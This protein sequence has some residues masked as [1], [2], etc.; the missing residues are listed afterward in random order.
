MRHK[1]VSNV[2]DFN[3]VTTKNVLVVVF[4]G[5]QRFD[6]LTKTFRNVYTYWLLWKT[7]LEII[8]C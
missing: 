4:P 2:K 6:K 7:L 1:D 3:T 5:E 8:D